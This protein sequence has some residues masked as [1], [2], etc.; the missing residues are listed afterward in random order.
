MRTCKKRAK[1]HPDRPLVARGLCSPCYSNW[2]R[3][4]NTPSKCH[5]DKPEYVAGSGVCQACYLREFKKDKDQARCHPDRPEH[6]IGSGVCQVC[7]NKQRISNLPPSKCHP[8]KPEILKG[9]GLCQSCYDRNRKLTLPRATCHPDRPVH[10]LESGLCA[11]CANKK[12]LYGSV[13][14]VVGKGCD[15]CGDPLKEGIGKSAMD[16][17][18][19]TGEL[20]GTLCGSCNKLLGFA[21]DRIDVLGSA[22][23]YLKK[24]TRVRLVG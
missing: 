13:V 8:D 21:R 23:E 9:S 6:I 22:I 19:S 16:H 12:R 20:R 5:P 10:I 1:C 2:R 4:Q 7:Y 24:H 18:H 15:I 3:K 14:S 11:C 17:D